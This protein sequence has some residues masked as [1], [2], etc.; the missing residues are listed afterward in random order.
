MAVLEIHL[1]AHCAFLSICD[2]PEDKRQRCVFPLSRYFICVLVS[3][4]SLHL[5]PPHISVVASTHACTSIGGTKTP[6][7]SLHHLLHWKVSTLLLLPARRLIC[8]L[9]A[10]LPVRMHAALQGKTRSAAA[11]AFGER[12]C[13]SRRGGC[14]PKKADGLCAFS[15][16]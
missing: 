14:S 11:A 3:I 13:D 7:A 6:A 9:P 5:P 1:E 10:D 16:P 12:T 8:L 4:P 15:R 2:N